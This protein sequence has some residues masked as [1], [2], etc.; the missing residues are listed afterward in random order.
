MAGTAAGSERHGVRAPLAP[1]RR[2]GVIRPLRIAA[3]LFAFVVFGPSVV[4]RASAAPPTKDGA[5]AEQLFGE[6]TKLLDEK[7]YADALPKL[8]ESQRLGPGIGV[9]MYLGDCYEGLGRT[10]KALALFREAE[11]MARAKKDPRE[12]VARGRIDELVP[13]VP[14][15]IVRVA[16]PAESDLS[17]SIDDDP[18]DAAR[19]GQQLELDPGP[20]VLHATS[21]ERRWE[22]AFDAPPQMATT[23]L[24]VPLR[25]EPTPAPAV[26][27]R[28]PTSDRRPLAIAGFAQMTTGV[29]VLGTGLLFGVLAIEKQK[30]SY[31]NGRCDSS[32]HC[33]SAG[34]ALRHDGLV[35]ARVSTVLVSVGLVLA[36]SGAVC[37]TL[38]VRQHPHAR[39]ALSVV[40]AA[41]GDVVPF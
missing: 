28:A 2:P 9:T 35:A 20:H 31:D 25:S 38:D 19:W 30:D 15:V 34:L 13:R 37:Y 14:S 17:V 32:A 4:G 3:W 24:T 6:G 21:S 33:D 22:L 23:I 12:S 8:L 36:A 10:A 16:T 41:I 39:L 29:L 11:Q 7:R 40:K 18:L 1:V 5:R 27:A 26:T